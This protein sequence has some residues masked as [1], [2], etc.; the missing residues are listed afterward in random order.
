MVDNLRYIQ[1]N[2]ILLKKKKMYLV[3]DV[4]EA[5]SS[6][7][8]SILSGRFDSAHVRQFDKVIVI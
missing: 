6:A 3:L 1:Q 2:K 4:E 7:K 8:L 5:G